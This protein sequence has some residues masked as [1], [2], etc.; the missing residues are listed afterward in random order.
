MDNVNAADFERN[1][2][3]VLHECA[4]E[5]H[6]PLLRDLKQRSLPPPDVGRDICDPPDHVIATAELAWPAVRV[7]VLYEDDEDARDA[8]SA[9]GWMCCFLSEATTDT[10]AEACNRRRL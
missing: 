7:A 4:E 2:S 8:C 10:I 6:V 5:A 3:A 1:W 9:A